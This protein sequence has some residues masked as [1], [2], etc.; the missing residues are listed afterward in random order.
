MNFENGFWRG[1]Y[2][3]SDAI[4]LGLLWLLA[5]IPIVTIGAST[6][7]AYTVALRW[8]RDEEGYTWKGFWKSFKE[9]FK[10]A[11]KVWC[12]LLL[13]GLF[14]A[15]DIWFYY[16]GETQLDQILMYLFMGLSIVW[17]VLFSYIFPII[18]RF[19]NSTRNY[20]KLAAGLS[21]RNFLW[22]LLILVLT[23]VLAFVIYIFI[24]PIYIFLIGLYQ[25]A[26]AR[27]MNRIF[28]PYV[29]EI[30]QKEIAAGVREPVVED[31]WE[32]DED[33]S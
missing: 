7:A 8:A 3:L 32:V 29:E 22:S 4:L 21:S 12:I 11:T 9:N 5:S 16:H 23:A 26:I 2:R 30:V 25:Y 10:P 15:L 17:I 18:A 28:K 27:I 20:F 31:P 19:S 6:T 1:L 33:K 24:I 14:F 13:I